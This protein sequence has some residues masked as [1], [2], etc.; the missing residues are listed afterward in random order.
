MKTDFSIVHFIS[1]SEMQIIQI[2]FKT[3]L[4]YL[5]MCVPVN[6]TYRV[7]VGDLITLIL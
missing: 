2:M 3:L 6:E 4:C 7:M 5:S 1:S